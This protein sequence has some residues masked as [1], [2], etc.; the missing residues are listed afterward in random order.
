[1]SYKT[2]FNALRLRLV[3]ILLPAV[4]IFSVFTGCFYEETPTPNYYPDPSLTY[5][6]DVSTFTRYL[7]KKGDHDATPRGYYPVSGNELRFSVVF[8]STAIYNT[9]EDYNQEDINKLYGFADNNRPHNDYSARFGWRW[10]N[11]KL[12]LFAYVHNAGNFMFKP[13]G[14]ITIGS[15]NRCAIKLAGNQ[16]IFSIN[17]SVQTVIP[18]MATTATIRGYRLYPYFGGDE[19][20]PHNIRVWIKP[21][22]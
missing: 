8:D 10:Y 12:T 13:V 16:Y 5:L 14:D 15:I 18:R 3:L 19:K 7:I 9:Y 4:I 22:L 1:M 11:Q 6:P 17:D 20:A 2:L 21:Q